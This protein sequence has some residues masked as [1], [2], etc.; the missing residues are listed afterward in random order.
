MAS[1]SLTRRGVVVTFRLLSGD[2]Q[3]GMEFVSEQ[4]GDW[5]QAT[6]V[7]GFI[8]PPPSPELKPP[9]ALLLRPLTDARRIQTGETFRSEDRI[10][11]E[12]D[13][14][15]DLFRCCGDEDLY[16]FQCS[17]CGWMMVF[18]YECDTL[19]S[20]LG[21]LSEHGRERVNH[22]EPEKPIFGCPKCG[23]LFEYYFMNNPVYSVLLRTWMAAGLGPLLVQRAQP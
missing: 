5:W 1:F 13:L 8:D 10:V 18:C 19:Y 22:F 17:Q 6:E 21:Q 7:G 16:P 2:F 9:L 4:Q 11:R 20:D 23:H 15:F 3:D 14:N 12:L